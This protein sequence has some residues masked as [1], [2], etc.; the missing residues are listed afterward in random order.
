MG[1]RKLYQKT[2]Y[3]EHFTEAVIKDE[4]GRLVNLEPLHL[5][6]HKFIREQR[7]KGRKRIGI[8]SHR[9]SGKSVNA[10]GVILPMIS[11]DTNIRGKIV[12]NVEG[13]AKKR[14]DALE[15]YIETDPDYQAVY[16]DIKPAYVRGK[17]TKKWSSFGFELERDSH[18]FDPTMEAIPVKGSPTSD[19]ADFLWFDDPCDEKDLRSKAHREDVKMRIKNAWLNIVTEEG[20]VL[21]TGTPWHEEDALHDFIDNPEWIWLVQ[22]VNKDLNGLKQVIKNG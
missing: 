21:W 17:R 2:K 8:I 1:K 6:W 13:N 20:W 16:P 4:K 22:V 15:S 12:T 3:T 19:R 5:E 9:D 7:A 10:L 18:S 11:E 14:I